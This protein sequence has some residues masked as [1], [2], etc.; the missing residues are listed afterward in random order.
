MEPGSSLVRMRCSCLISSMGPRRFA[1]D[2]GEDA[3]TCMHRLVDEIQQHR[4]Q[5]CLLSYSGVAKRQSHATWLSK[6][7]ET[8]CHGCAHTKHVWLQCDNSLAEPSADMHLLAAT[9]TCMFNLG[10]AGVTLRVLLL[11]ALWPISARHEAWLA[12]GGHGHA[13]IC[14]CSCCCRPLRVCILLLLLLQEQLLLLIKSCLGK[15]LQLVR[16]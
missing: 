3:G 5:R 11:H 13:S 7:H 10:Q 8:T 12:P 14:C 1:L 4:L 16:T 15:H 6:S 9:P 2:P